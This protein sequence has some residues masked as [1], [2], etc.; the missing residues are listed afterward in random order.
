MSRHDNHQRPVA[1]RLFGLLAAIATVLA[2]ALSVP[3][4]AAGAT[5]VSGTI[6]GFDCTELEADYAFR[7]DGNLEGCVY[8]TITEARSHLSGTYQEVADEIFIGTYN[9]QA[10]T[11]EMTEFYTEKRIDGVLEFARCKH[12]IVTGSGTGVFE[13]VTGRLDFKD[14]VVAGTSEYKG[15]LSL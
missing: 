3:A 15:H 14:D 11:F 6:V 12:P 10:G 13:G 8:G 9:G 7:I 4:S 5:Q 1:R 2:T